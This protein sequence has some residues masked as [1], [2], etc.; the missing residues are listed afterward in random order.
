MDRRIIDQYALFPAQIA[1]GQHYSSLITSMFLH[2]SWLHVG[3]NML[4][5]WI[6][7]NNVEDALGSLKFTL[8]YLLSGIAGSLLQVYADPASTIPNL[9][10]SGAIS[11]VLA[12]YVFYYPRARVLTLILPFFL[13]TL[14]AFVFIGYWFLLQA[15]QA[16]V[17]IGVERGGVAFF[18]HIGGFVAGL[19][20]ALLFRPRTRYAY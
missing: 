8:L 12:A 19:I 14:S 18:A 5:L 13:V 6:F 9:G 4:F 10:A 11:G 2:A 17:S 16:L 7:G 1:S 3:G 15:F 20:L